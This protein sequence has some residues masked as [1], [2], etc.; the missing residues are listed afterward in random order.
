M[1]QV[2]RRET[3]GMWAGIASLVLGLVLLA[4]LA[5]PEDSALRHNGELTSFAAPL[6]RM[7]VSLIFL[8]FP[9]PGVVHGYVAVVVGD[10]PTHVAPQ[11]ICPE[12][13]RR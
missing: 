2:T 5:S 8:L 10:N 6:M 7:I 9:V 4:L 11:P 12:T 13:A 1:E 3:L